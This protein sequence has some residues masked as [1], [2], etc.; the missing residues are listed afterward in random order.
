MKNLEES[1]EILR[2]MIQSSDTDRDAVASVA[3]FRRR[4]GKLS[5]RQTVSALH[6]FGSVEYLKK[7]QPHAKSVVKRAEK[8]LIGVQP[9]SVQRRKT[10]NGSRRREMIGRPSISSIPE[11]N[12]GKRKRNHSLGNNIK[13]NVASAKK[14]S[15]NMKSLTRKTFQ[16]SK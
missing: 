2:N 16:K 12:P 8:R 10:E 6:K 3:T 7:V 1:F 13:K 14:H 11:P 5:T 9:T 4:L 15:A